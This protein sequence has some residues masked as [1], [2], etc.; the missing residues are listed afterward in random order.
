[1]STRELTPARTLA[2]LPGDLRAAVL[3]FTTGAPRL[4]FPGTNGFRWFLTAWAP[5][6]PGVYVI[7]VC[8]EGQGR[9]EFYAM[10]TRGMPP[11]IHASDTQRA[12][13]RTPRW[14]FEQ[15]Q[16]VLERAAAPAPAPAADPTVTGENPYIANVMRRARQIGSTHPS[17]LARMDLAWLD[18][19]LETVGRAI[20]AAMTPPGER[21]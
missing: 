4:D 6:G 21:L 13:Q 18:F 16:R 19:H 2:D 17:V 15:A 7:R 11:R 8:V 3:S 12:D 14:A 5:V 10:E 20:D 1:M 9:D